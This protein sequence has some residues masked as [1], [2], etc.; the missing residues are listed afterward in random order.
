MQW[1][2]KWIDTSSVSFNLTDVFGSNFKS[3]SS[4]LLSDGTDTSFVFKSASRISRSVILDDTLVSFSS[5]LFVKLLRNWLVVS[6]KLF[7]A[8]IVFWIGIGFNWKR[9]IKDII[10]KDKQILASNKCV[11]AFNYLLGVNRSHCHVRSKM[12]IS[13]IF[14]NPPWIW[15]LT[16]YFDLE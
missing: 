11:E 9:K 13:I 10:R 15:V 2:V 12:L 4:L 16:G 6:T 7:T 8:S 3:E 1:M 14:G 5:Q